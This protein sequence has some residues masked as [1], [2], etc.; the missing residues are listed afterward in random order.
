MV[1]M[2]FFSHCFVVALAVA[3]S[4]CSQE[5]AAEEKSA[6]VA[7]D[8]ATSKVDAKADDSEIASLSQEVTESLANDNLVGAALDKVYR[9]EHKISVGTN[10]K[11]AV[12]ET[13]TLRAFLRWPHR[14]IMMVRRRAPIAPATTSRSRGTTAARSWQNR[15]SL[16]SR[17]IRRARATATS[18]P[19]A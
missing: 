14:A 7:D 4:A 9:L 10:K 16:P 17:W 15:A 1:S 12:T 11:I 2:R 18:R 13:F 8:T 6:V 3:S 19:M 5:S